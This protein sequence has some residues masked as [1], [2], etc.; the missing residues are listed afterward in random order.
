MPLPPLYK[1]LDIKGARLTL[2][3]RCFR[4]AK[5]STFNDTEDLT[6]AGMFP[7]PIEDAVKGIA[8]NF[9]DVILKNVDRAPACSNKSLKAKVASFQ[10]IF[11]KRPEMA[12]ILKLAITKNAAVFDLD[13]PI[14]SA[15]AAETISD[16]N[17]LMQR[18]RV[19]CVTT[20]IES[21]KMWSEYT[22]GH[23]GI[24][25]RIVGNSEK[26]SKFEKFCK[27]SYVEKRPAIYDSAAAYLESALFADRETRSRDTMNKIIYSKTL[28]WSYESEYRLVI[29]LEDG[30]EWET[31]S[32]HPEEIVELYLGFSIDENDKTDIVEKA[33]SLNPAIVIFQMKRNGAGGLVWD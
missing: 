31:L 15:L 8:A 30:E 20:H 26:A 9:V 2:D 16:I 4:H 10:K 28:K 3:G 33:I 18:H 12:G 32:F 24:A 7:E 25:L 23:R 22:K 19:L 13:V 6:V 27:V 14:I 11:K 1:Y 17:E 29:Y 21:E 5:P